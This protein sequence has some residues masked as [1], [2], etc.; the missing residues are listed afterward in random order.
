M[1]HA[2]SQGEE[3]QNMKEKTEANHENTKEKKKHEIEKLE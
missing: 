2:S 1:N 3:P